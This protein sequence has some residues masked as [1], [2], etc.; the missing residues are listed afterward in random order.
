MPRPRGPTGRSGL[1]LRERHV[2]LLPTVLP[3]RRRPEAVAPPAGAPAPGLSGEPLPSE[4]ARWLHDKYE[5]LA[6]EEGQ[7]AGS[8]TSYY[9]AIGTVL[10]TGLIVVFVDLANQRLLLTL[11]VTFLALLGMMISVVWAV[12]L[13]RTTDAQNMW[14]EAARWLE[15]HHPPVMTSVPAPI[16]LRSG[17]NL[18]V[19]LSK[20]F[21]AH[22]AR[23]AQDRQI[24]AMDRVN[25]ATL[26]EILP[27]TFLALW[28]IILVA[29]W[30]WYFTV[31]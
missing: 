19:D 16:T 14:R 28:T 5:R 18:T 11:F 23:F 26:T 6:A 20:P 31:H 22:A 1:R 15:Q 29:D 25:P 9:A 2:G 3:A 8:R 7:L 30:V 13:H 12:L 27:Q 4:D 17:A 24:S 10:I 21:S